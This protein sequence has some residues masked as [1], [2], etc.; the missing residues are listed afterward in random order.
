M[1]NILTLVMAVI[2]AFGV[3]TYGKALGQ[4]KPVV[5]KLAHIN[6][7]DGMIDKQAKKFAELVAARTKGRVKIEVFPASQL[8]N[9]IEQIEA[10]SMG[11]ID[12]ILESEGMLL[13]LDKDF[14]IFSVPFLMTKEIISKNE[15][16]KELRERVRVKNNIRILPGYGWRP[17][18]HLWTRKKIVRTPDELQGMKIRKVQSKIQI[19]VWNGLGATAVPI[20]WGEVYMALA[21]GIVDG[22]DHNIV[23]IYEEKFYE[24]LKYCTLLNCLLVGQSV[25]VNEKLFSRL[26]PDVQKAMN[27]SGIEAG[28]Y[29]TA[30]AA[31]LEGDAKKKMEEA[32]IQFVQGDRKAWVTKASN[33]I[34]KLEDEGVWSK[35]LLKKIGLE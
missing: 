6:V 10:V 11:S 12:M 28:D 7:A 22:L 13:I 33:V 27:E 32:G 24:Q 5:L 4:E 30:L 3:F 15:F 1:K 19:D 23:Q 20:P 18:F 34:K 25:L 9:M 2:F 14:G 35:G 26:S 31:S 17:D 29:F 8:G 21:Q 16:L